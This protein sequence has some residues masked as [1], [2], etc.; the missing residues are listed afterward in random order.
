MGR[1]EEGQVRELRPC[2]FCEGEGREVGGCA[3]T[4]CS[5]CGSY[6]REEVRCVQC[7]ASAVDAEDWNNRPVPELPEGYREEEQGDLVSE[8]PNCF[9]AWHFGDGRIMIDD[10]DDGSALISEKDAQALAI[11]LQRRSK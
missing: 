6:S 11:W 3:S 1:R 7:N 10:Q 5:A 9:S 8:P 2:P 4:A